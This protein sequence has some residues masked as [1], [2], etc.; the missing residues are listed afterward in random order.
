MVN[1]CFTPHCD[2]NYE[3]EE[4]K[5]ARKSTRINGKEEGGGLHRYHR[6]IGTHQMNRKYT[7]AKNISRLL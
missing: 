1:E 3:S 5:A 4:E 7:F 2:Y 6:K